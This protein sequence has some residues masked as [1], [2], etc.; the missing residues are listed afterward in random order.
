MS[1]QHATPAPAPAPAGTPAAAPQIHSGQL[2]P[3]HDTT[4]GIVNA[5]C[6]TADQVGVNYDAGVDRSDITDYAI[7]VL[8][9]ICSK[10]C[11]RSV[12]ISSGV[13]S[14]DSQAR[15]M[16]QNAQ[17]HGVASQ[18]HLYGPEG[19][20]VL[21][22]Y[23]QGVAHGLD[24][25]TIEANMT[26]VINQHPGAFHHVSRA[27]NLSVFDVRPSSVEGGDTNA[28]HRLVSEARADARVVR[29]FQPPNDPGY[30]FEIQNP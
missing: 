3:T 5:Q 4:P 12:V 18:R 11:V 1:D 28:G 21:D 19:N 30:H 26:Q 27:A 7:L 14:S 22:Q 25:A 24:Q 10:A 13:R 17:R 2:T 15:A 16:Y 23:E 6:P 9:Q 8:T 29:F 20:L